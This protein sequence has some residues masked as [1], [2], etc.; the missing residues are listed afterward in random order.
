MGTIKGFLKL[1]RGMRKFPRNCLHLMLVITLISFSLRSHS[2]S[3]RWRTELDLFTSGLRVCRN[4]AKVHYN[5]AKKLVDK[6]RGEEAVTFYKEAVRLEPNYEQALNN[7]GNLLKSEKKFEEAEAH[8]RL[9]TQVNPK[10]A[11][12]FMNLGI[13]QQARKDFKGAELS[14]LRALELRTP[15]ADCEYNLGN[16][17]LR[18]G[19]LLK[20]EDRFRTT[21]RVTRGR[22]EKALANLV[23]LLDETKRLGEAVELGQQAVAF[24]PNKPEFVF[25]LAN[26][27]GKQ[28]KFA[29]SETQYLL[30]LSMQEKAVYRSNLG[31][32][33]HRWGRM[34]DAKE[35]YQRA[36]LMNP[37]LQSARNYLQKLN[38]QN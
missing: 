36:L 5:I 3:S 27:L 31:V 24:F 10:F 19:S 13:V 7:L 29:A 30:A 22:H 9:A 1:R 35:Q 12:A 37:A 26:I 34:E 2:R 6:H 4:N 25:N 20:A 14:Y 16:L 17:H 28:G 38:S 33:Y 15:Y 8:L 11:A 23:L 18:T 21:L 32:L